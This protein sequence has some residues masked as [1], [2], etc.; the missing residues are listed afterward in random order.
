MNERRLKCLFEIAQNPEIQK[1]LHE[2]IDHVL[3]QRE[4][5]LTY[6]SI[7]D[8]KYLECC[9]DGLSIRSLLPF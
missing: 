3:A 4:G 9:I 5:E 8:L 1:K 7:N 6:D 2:E